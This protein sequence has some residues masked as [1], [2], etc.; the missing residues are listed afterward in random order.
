MTPE[1]QRTIRAALGD[2]N[3]DTSRF[4]VFES[5]ALSTEPLSKGGFFSKARVSP[6]TLKDMEAFLSQPASAIPLHI[7]HETDG[8]LPVG[9]VFS[10]K[11]YAMANGEY[12]LRSQFYLPTEEAALIAKIETSVVDE[13]SVGIQT[14]HAFC[15]ECNYD[16]FAADSDVM[17][18]FT[19]TC[20]D[21]H[22]IGLDGV[23]VRL[24]GLDDWSELSLVGQGAANKAKIL[25]RDQQVMSKDL[26]ERLA[27]G[28]TSTAIRLTASYKMDDKVKL[29]TTSQ[30]ESTM[31]PKDF[32]T[33]LEATSTKLTSTSV[34][35]ARATDAVAALTAENTALKASATEKDAKIKELEAAQGTSTKELTD[36]LAASQAALK[37]AEDVVAPHVKAALVASGVAEADVPT[38]LPAMVKLVEDKGLKLHQIITPGAKSVDPK[39]DLSKTGSADLAKK[40][41][42]KLS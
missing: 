29:P 37:A 25:S 41:A 6:Q 40:S 4:V 3:A 12:E 33:Q 15:S 34:E 2:P 17:N 23:H 22:Q 10:A 27:A 19:L 11:M 31:D 26:V 1:L 5:R 42:F 39:T 30:G 28:K 7:M 14:Q 20:P 32:L 38:E 36:K 35:L 24:V 13:V 18:F 21:G 9:K 8:P 16:Y